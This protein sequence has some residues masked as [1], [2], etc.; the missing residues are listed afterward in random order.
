[1]VNIKLL[2][3]SILQGKVNL[4]V[5]S[6]YRRVSDLFI[7]SKEPFIVI[8]DV[9]SGEIHGTTLI[10]NKSCIMWIMPMEAAK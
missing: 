4:A 2:D 1:M 5:G 7:L 8:S 10:I 6:G 3:G 9:A